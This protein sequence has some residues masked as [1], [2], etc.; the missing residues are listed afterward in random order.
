[1]TYLLRI[2]CTGYVQI[3]SDIQQVKAGL[4]I[5]D[6]WAIFFLRTQLW[7]VLPEIVPAF[8]CAYNKDNVQ[9]TKYGSNI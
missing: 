6:N 5:T 9:R 8:S 3:Y 1:M 4:A 2:N 7:S